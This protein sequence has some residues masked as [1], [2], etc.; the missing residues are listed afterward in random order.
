MSIMCP[1]WALS[2]V[3]FSHFQS[4][5]RGLGGATGGTFPP[6]LITSHPGTLFSH[7]QWTFLFKCARTQFTGLSYWV[8]RQI[9]PCPS[10]PLTLEPF[11]GS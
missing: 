4:W 5:G 10:I 8:P 2:N 3:F 11:P 1:S 9:D 6:S 7:H